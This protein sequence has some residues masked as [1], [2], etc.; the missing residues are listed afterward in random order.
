MIVDVTLWH[1]NTVALQHHIGSHGEVTVT[2]TVIPLERCC[3][4]RAAER[5]GRN[6]SRLIGTESGGI[7][8]LARLGTVRGI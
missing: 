8:P 4:E 7:E 5:N 1:C 2:A 3:T 6:E